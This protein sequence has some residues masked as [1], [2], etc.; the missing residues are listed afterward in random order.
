MLITFERSDIEQG[1]IGAALDQ[2]LQISDSPE[3]R[4]ELEGKVRFVFGG[5]SNTNL[6]PCEIPECRRFFLSLTTEWP[7]WFHYL[8]KG[9]PDVPV[10]LSLLC[11]I[12]KTVGDSGVRISFSDGPGLQLACNRLTDGLMLLQGQ[13]GRSKEAQETTLQQIREELVSMGR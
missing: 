9:T 10:A 1:L 8:P 7:F 12:E 6:L 2:L 13:M 4:E 11:D 5:W 3:R